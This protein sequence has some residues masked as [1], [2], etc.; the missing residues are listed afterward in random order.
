MDNAALLTA[1]QG[2]DAEAKPVEKAD[3]A[4]VSV[5]AGRLFDYL[6]K[7]R[8]TP[9]LQFDFLL[10]H[11]AVHWPESGKF[12][13]IY[14]FYSTTLRHYAMVTTEV[15]VENPVVK[16]AAPLWA[17]AEWQ[18]R[19]VYDLFGVLYEGHPDLRRLFLDDTWTGFPLRKDYKDDF[20]LE[21]E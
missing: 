13:L 17:I 12:E 21:R 19:E 7:V 9:E 15:P 18:E 8:S 16:S 5:P 6:A 20:M 14:Q 10:A 1:L 2:L 11:T 4:A 3:R